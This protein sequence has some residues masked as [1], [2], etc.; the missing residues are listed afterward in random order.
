MQESAGEGKG[1]KG[2]VN[3]VCDREGKGGQGKGRAR[4]GEIREDGSIG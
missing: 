4:E 1:R 3:R 2:R